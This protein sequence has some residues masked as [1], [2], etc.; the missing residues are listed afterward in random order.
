MHLVAEDACEETDLGELAGCLGV[1]AQLAN[2][3]RD[4]E[5]ALY[6]V[7]D[8][9]ELTQAVMV[10][11]LAPALGG[12]ALLAGLGTRIPSR[13]ARTAMAYMT[14]TTTA[15][16]CTAVGHTDALSSAAA[17]RRSRAGRPIAR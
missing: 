11:L 4:R 14:I 16:L 6:G 12:F 13:G 2:D 5:L 9:E 7:G 1:I 17:A 10:R 3:L 8:A 15:F